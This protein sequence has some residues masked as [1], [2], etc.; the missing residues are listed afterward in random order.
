[1][2]QLAKAKDI[3]LIGTKLLHS[4]Q[5]IY[6]IGM[7][8][9]VDSS[10]CVHLDTFTDLQVTSLLGVHVFHVYVIT[11]PNQLQSQR[12]VRSFQPHTTLQ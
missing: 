3:Q 11:V 2:K 10:L 8:F 1:M 7:C 9:S 12:N 4:F 6:S 5:I